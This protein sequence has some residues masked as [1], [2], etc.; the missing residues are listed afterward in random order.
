MKSK[1]YDESDKN[2]E[3]IK[4]VNAEREKERSLL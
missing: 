3:E 1:I 4:G 2:T